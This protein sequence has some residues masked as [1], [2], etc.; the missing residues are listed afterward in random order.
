[1]KC[2]R[3]ELIKRY[4]VFLLALI[5]GA[6]GVVVVTRADIGTNSVMCMSYV[7]SVYF[8][9]TMGTVTILLYLALVII[10]YIMFTPQERKDE[11]VS[12]LMQMPSL[13]IF[14]LLV[15]LFMF[16]TSG[17]DFKAW[18]YAGQLATFVI[19]SVII[20]FNIALQAVAS[21]A[22][23]SSDAFVILIAER[24]N[25]RIGSIKLIF[26]LVMVLMAA[27]ISLFSTNF[28]TLTSIREGSFIGL[29]IVGPSIQL[30]LPH[31]GIF[32]RWFAKSA[33]VAEQKKEVKP[34]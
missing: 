24:L 22:K 13:F 21:V 6:F 5:C 32:R 14:G 17:I 16:L 27:A 1:M 28:T 25:K 18:G 29:F 12:L 26:D 9:I 7:T 11:L 33:I 8:P 10:Q 4:L 23:I 3:N 15:D 20:G 2:S 30:F 34:K 31:L 19:G